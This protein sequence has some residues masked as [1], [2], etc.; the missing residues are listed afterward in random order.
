MKSSEAENNLHK[1]EKISIK[2]DTI[3]K[4]ISEVKMRNIEIEQMTAEMDMLI[5]V[6]DR[7][8]SQ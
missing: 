8:V 5:G 6:L 2:S 7:A 4:S 1:L 3:N